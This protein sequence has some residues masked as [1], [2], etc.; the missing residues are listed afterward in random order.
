MIDFNPYDVK[1]IDFCK[2]ER[3]LTFF[4][5]YHGNRANEIAT[6]PDD[7]HY[8]YQD[9]FK[10]EI[11]PQKLYDSGNL[12]EAIYIQEVRINLKLNSDL[13]V[14]LFRKEN[15]YSLSKEYKIQYHYLNYWN[16]ERRNLEENTGLCNKL[17]VLLDKDYKIIYTGLIDLE[18]NTAAAENESMEL[19]LYSF[20]YLLSK[21]EDIEVALFDK[22]YVTQYNNVGQFGLN[23]FQWPA[24]AWEP[25][26][27]SGERLRVPSNC[28]NLMILEALRYYFG[29]DR[30]L[31]NYTGPGGYPY[32]PTLKNYTPYPDAKSGTFYLKKEIIPQFLP[33][34]ID[35]YSIYQRFC[36]RIGNEI[37]IT[38]SEFTQEGNSR[39]DWYKVFKFYLND[40]LDLLNDTMIFDWE[41]EANYTTEK[42]VS[43]WNLFKDHYQINPP[44]AGEA[45]Q[46]PG[47]SDG[48]WFNRL[49]L[50]QEN[51]QSHLVI[52]YNL[53]AVLDLDICEGSNGKMLKLGDLA[54]LA[55]CYEMW[56]LDITANQ[57]G[58]IGGYQVEK[59]YLLDTAYHDNSYVNQIAVLSSK[60]LIL[61]RP[62]FSCFDIL[63]LNEEAGLMLK[64]TYTLL[65]NR[66]LY[67]VPC[68]EVEAVTPFKHTAGEIASFEGVGKFVV[69]ETQPI[70]DQSGFQ[71]SKNRM[72][73]LSYVD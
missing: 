65:Y 1:Y 49:K 12:T 15:D 27:I 33:G 38:Y 23:G 64:K 4:E 63:N 10:I 55:F 28:I 61:K 43:F 45:T 70:Y 56:Y 52:A 46:W 31:I 13:I 6:N 50:I 16:A 2:R 21:V 41:I 19:K 68:E 5:M 48:S 67:S 62:D 59:K 42:P 34:N 44:A 11:D 24:G 39:T 36:F 35:H 25:P 8:L 73:R 3:Y 51:N 32:G 71:Y 18:D 30:R 53:P 20:T 47:W 29:D 7:S 60:R 57:D 9:A 37:Y 40:D 22:S 17:A 14:K 72:W 26:P 69:I 66:R 58:L 54:R